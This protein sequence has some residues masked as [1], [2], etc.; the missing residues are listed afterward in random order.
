MS[1]HVW[2]IQRPTMTTSSLP[3]SIPKG[4]VLALQN[5]EPAQ[6]KAESIKFL[7]SP[8]LCAWLY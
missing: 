1:G 8:Q 2:L 6:Y 4:L 3:P 7:S 5:R